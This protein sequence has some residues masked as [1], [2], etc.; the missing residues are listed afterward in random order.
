M[1]TIAEPCSN[2]HCGSIMNKILN[3][4]ICESL[5]KL[6]PSKKKE[7]SKDVINQAVNSN[8]V[9]LEFIMAMR[10]IGWRL[11]DLK[12]SGVIKRTNNFWDLV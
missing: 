1:D 12:H 7:I 11:Q 2:K 4:F 8:L 9:T 3:M 10:D 5:K 6:G